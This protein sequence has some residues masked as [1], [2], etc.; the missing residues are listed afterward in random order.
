MIIGK[1]YLDL[2]PKTL[3]SILKQADLKKI[4]DG[5][6]EICNHHREG[7]AKSLC[8]LPRPSRRGRSR[9]NYRGGGRADEG[10]N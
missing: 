2:H 9:R 7:R 10:S 4:E 6:K 5:Q 1:P 3:K 8:I